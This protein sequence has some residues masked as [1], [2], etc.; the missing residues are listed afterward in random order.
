MR[1]TVLALLSLVL[2][3]AGGCSRR[4]GATYTYYRLNV[5]DNQRR[6]H[7]EILRRTKGV[8]DVK[9]MHD[10]NGRLTLTLTLDR[11]LVEPG[12]LKAEELGYSYVRDH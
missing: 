10:M 9:H 7:I 1:Q 5:N 11:A 4:P 2:L 8:L 3:A 6:E 12:Q